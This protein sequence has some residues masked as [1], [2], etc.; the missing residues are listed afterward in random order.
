MVEPPSCPS[1]CQLALQLLTQ[2]MTRQ[3]IALADLRALLTG[4]F[5][6]LSPV[7]MAEEA[8]TCYFRFFQQAR[9]PWLPWLAGACSSCMQKGHFSG[10][11]QGCANL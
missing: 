7:R 5:P 2:A 1:D 11:P 9:F 8:F 6:S 4:S 10:D 3:Q